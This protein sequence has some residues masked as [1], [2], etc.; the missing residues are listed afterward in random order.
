MD[1]LALIAIIVIVA[2]LVDFR[3][4]IA[5]A[6]LVSLALGVARKVGGLDTWLG[7]RPLAFLG[8]I[9]Y[10]VF[11]LNFPV[12]L[13]INALFS[14]FAN[15]DPMLNAVGVLIAWAGSIAAGAMFYRF[16]ESRTG[17]IQDKAL[18]LG[19]AL[20]IDP[21]QRLGGRLMFAL[22]VQR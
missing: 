21:A 6:L 3:S 1:W 5:V 13:V 7:A 4:R 22:R 10:S 12:C 2:L 17:Q 16:V 18:Y 9:S 14:R 20:L 15:D 8:R 11:L 19:R